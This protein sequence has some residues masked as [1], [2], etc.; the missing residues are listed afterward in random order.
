V[1]L[2]LLQ[3]E[4]EHIDA[5]ALLARVRETMKHSV[6]GPSGLSAPVAS[7]RAVSARL[8]E[9]DRALARASE[10]WAVGTRVPPM[11]KLKGLFR[12]VATPAAKAILR[13][14]ELVTRDQRDFNEAMLHALRQARETLAGQGP[15]IGE[16]VT[17]QVQRR[18][19]ELQRTVAM[20]IEEEQSK[21]GPEL[22]KL[23]AD[24]ESH[25]A[26][27]LAQGTLLDEQRR[28]LEALRGELSQLNA[29]LK[30][31]AAR[32]DHLRHGLVLQERRL[33]L[34]IEEARRR[35]PAPL[36]GSQLQTFVAEG[37]KLRD[38]LYPAFEDAF[39]GS[40]E[41][42]RLRLAA[43]LPSLREANAGSAGRPIVD[44]GCGRGEFL[45]LLRE[46]S[47][48]AMGIDTNEEM[49]ARACSSGLEVIRAD[50]LEHLRALPD[51]SLG[52]V[53]AIHVIEH[54]PLEAILVLFEECA[55]VL[56]PGGIAIFETPNPENVLVGACNFY[57]DPT[58]IR[59][60]HP[61][62]MQYLAEARGL[63]RVRVEYFRPTS[64]PVLE[65]SP[66]TEWIKNTMLGP[67]DYAV[68]GYRP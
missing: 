63:T 58:H 51:A 24:A 18:F 60:L 1:S 40:M 19:D 59:P 56:K 32:G 52:G 22:A 9:L 14:A 53:T 33:T 29:R 45:D 37:Q 42:I 46:N 43:Y 20:E 61:S 8:Q 38:A 54:L 25:K 5:E 67:Q 28:V 34:L 31:E 39:R 15:A 49:V 35:L 7:G 12:M 4:D 36:D 3:V 44:I 65:G 48:E 26:T 50:A 57:M 47:L 41:E 55:R 66:A 2:P 62:T 10:S 16:Q 11:H 68:V 6:A 13:M 17:E 23:R 64:A 30:D 27:L 21:R